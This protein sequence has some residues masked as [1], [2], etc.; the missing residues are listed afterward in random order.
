MYIIDKNSQENIKKIDL[1]DGEIEKIIC[2]YDNHKINLPV[3]L[4]NSNLTIEAELIF[5]NVV[6]IDISIYEPWGEGKYINEVIV[7]DS[8]DILERLKDCG[9]KN[10]YIHIDILIN[11]GDNINIICKRVVYVQY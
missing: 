4:Y 7:N 8:L 6:Y 3:K 2:D 9:N 5:E 10:D 11:S 1:H